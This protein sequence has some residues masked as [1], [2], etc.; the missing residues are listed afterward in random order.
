[1]TATA[2]PTNDSLTLLDVVNSEVNETQEHIVSGWGPCKSCD[3]SGYV[4][5]GE[6][7]YTCKD[8]D[9]HFSQHRY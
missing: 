3:C 5:K 4:S 6:G 1:M 9:H 2:N 7:I 8:C